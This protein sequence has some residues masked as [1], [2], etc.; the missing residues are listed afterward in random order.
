[1]RVMAKRWKDSN[2]KGGTEYM[3]EREH[4]FVAELMTFW[5]TIPLDYFKE[6]ATSL[7]GLKRYDKNSA[8]TSLAECPSLLPVRQAIRAQDFS[9]LTRLSHLVNPV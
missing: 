9:K 6:C 1:M 4:E 8:C 5:F 3:R 2:C 7:E